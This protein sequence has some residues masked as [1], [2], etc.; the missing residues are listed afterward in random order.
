MSKKI[1][2]NLTLTSEETE[3]HSSEYKSAGIVTKV[4]Y[5]NILEKIHI[6]FKEKKRTEAKQI[7]VEICIKYLDIEY[8]VNKQ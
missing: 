4:S 2:G 7:I 5:R 3:E 1:Q 6:N 8:L